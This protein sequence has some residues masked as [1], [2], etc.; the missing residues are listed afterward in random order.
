M[1][2]CTREELEAMAAS[3]KA[4][5]NALASGAV[6]SYSIDGRSLTRYDLP[7][8]RSMLEWIAG[9]LAELDGSR[10]IVARPMIRR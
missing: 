1:S 2:I 8:I 3:W 10:R 4:A 6:Q 9:Q 7:K 5:L